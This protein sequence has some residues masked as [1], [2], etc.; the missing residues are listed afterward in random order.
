MTEQEN[1][2]LGYRRPAS[3]L[4]VRL[5]RGSD[6]R[7]IEE[8]LTGGAGEQGQLTLWCVVYAVKCM[9]SV[10]SIISDAM[11]LDT[12]LRRIQEVGGRGRKRAASR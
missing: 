4:L 3:Y 12:T 9:Y 7:P 5:T 2:E 1:S 8:A 11:V 6:R 10:P